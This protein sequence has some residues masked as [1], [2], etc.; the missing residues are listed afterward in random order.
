VSTTKKN[1]QFVPASSIQKLETGDSLTLVRWSL[2]KTFQIVHIW[3]VSSSS[4]IRSQLPFRE[5]W[6]VVAIEAAIQTRANQLEL[7][8]V[9][10]KS[11]LKVEEGEA[12]YPNED[13]FRPGSYLFDQVGLTR[14]PV[15]HNNRAILIPKAFV[16]ALMHQS[17]NDGNFVPSTT[18]FSVYAGLN[19]PDLYLAQKADY[20]QK[21]SIYTSQT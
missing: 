11:K 20:D 18:W 2:E 15:T 6:K 4:D 9:K 14:I 16:A 13:C 1:L 3:G 21:F 8:V 12:F 17:L 7:F 5:L 19:P 10:R